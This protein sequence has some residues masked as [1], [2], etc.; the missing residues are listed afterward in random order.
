[1]TL[2]YKTFKV[3]L[4][5]A[6]K[7]DKPGEGSAVIATLNVI[8]KDED[9]TLPGA[10]GT[11][12]V[13]MMPAHQSQEPRLGKAILTEADGMA[14]ADF[15]FNL[16]PDAVRAKEWY[17]ALKFDME[18]G[19]PLQEWSYGFK[20]I[21]SEFGE[22]QGKQVRF[23]KSLKVFEISPVLRGAGVGTGTLAIKDENKQTF[24]TEMTNA[25][26]SLADVERVLTRAKS[27]A[28]L[29]AKDGRYL[30]KENQEDMKSLYALLD[31]VLQGC[32]GIIQ[33]AQKK[34]I[35]VDVLELEYQKTLQDY[36]HLIGA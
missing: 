10:F 19:D 17:A 28:E 7:A 33:K 35:D 11:Q 36:G 9:V 12:H 3:D 23:L 1:M 14:V 29:R 32:G 34:G 21:E 20:I 8:D 18:N 16:A 25:L 5:T 30:S 26:A 24:K 2:L 27:L 13:N 15:K 4:S 6:L 22:F 31:G